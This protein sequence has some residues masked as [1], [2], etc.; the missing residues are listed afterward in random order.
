MWF[1]LRM[2]SLCEQL[3]HLQVLLSLR[4]L[5]FL[6]SWLLFSKQ[7]KTDTCPKTLTSGLVSEIHSFWVLLHVCILCVGEAC[8]VHAIAP[9][10]VQRQ[11]ME[12]SSFPLSHGSWESNSGPQ[13]EQWAPLPTDSSQ[14]SRG[15]FFPHWQGGETPNIDH[16]YGCHIHLQ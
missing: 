1:K 10:E 12:T 15:L 4:L 7:N 3:L 2:N 8:D 9:T 11:P 16:T 14:W 6:L 13:V 5:T